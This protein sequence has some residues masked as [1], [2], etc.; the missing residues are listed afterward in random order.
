M[1]DC[2]NVGTSSAMTD[3]ALSTHTRRSL[4]TLALI[5]SKSFPPIAMQSMKLENTRPL[6]RS[7]DGTTAS[8]VGYHRNTGRV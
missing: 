1:Y 6:G 5:W 8:S 7:W 4:R 2:V 3:T